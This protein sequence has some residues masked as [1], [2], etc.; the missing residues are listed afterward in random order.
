M[1]T[2]SAD[3]QK[4]LI[5]I[6][7]SLGGIDVKDALSRSRNE[8][9][10]ID[11]IL[12][13]TIGV[14]FLGT[15]HYRFKKASLAKQVMNLAKIFNQDTDTKIIRALEEKSDVLDGVTRGFG[16][17]LSAGKIEV[18]SFQEAD[19]TN[20][21]MVVETHSS[22]IGYLDETAGTIHAD[23]RNMAKFRSEDGKGF[24]SVVAVLHRWLEEPNQSESQPSIAAK[25]G[26]QP[27]E[28]PDGLISD[29]KF[30]REYEDCVRSLNIAEARDHMQNVE[31][32]YKDTYNWLFDSQ[33]CFRR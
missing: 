27:S 13:A 24:Q 19:R 29:E 7:H 21:V 11:E 6:A 23:H 30:H 20:G 5:F 4:N 12:S 9:T 16:Q 17:V 15:S 14:I 31:P 3:E 8:T 28:L 10:W 26:I 1:R 33:V 32:A 25:S 18:H 22:R 2:S